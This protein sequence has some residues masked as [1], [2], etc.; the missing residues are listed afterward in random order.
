MEDTVETGE[1]ELVHGQVESKDL[2]PARVLSLQRRVVVVGEAID[3]DDLVPARH[4][5]FAQVRADEPGCAGDGIPHPERVLADLVGLRVT[6][7]QCGEV[8]HARRV[9]HLLPMEE[10]RLIG[11]LHHA[12]TG[13]DRE[14]VSG[15]AGE[16]DD[17]GV[18]IAERIGEPVDWM[19]EMTFQRPARVTQLRK[20]LGRRQPGQGPMGDGVRSDRDPGSGPDVRPVI[21]YSVAGI[22]SR[23]STGE[24]YQSTSR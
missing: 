15:L 7:K 19:A 12:C 1:I 13:R 3:P 14:Q 21:T 10:Q 6:T 23:S 4:E 9:D 2:A 5:R 16:R 11:V 24:A 18:L 22:R 20:S 17:A 8:S